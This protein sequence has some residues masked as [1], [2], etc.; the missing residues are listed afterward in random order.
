[1]KERG[2]FPGIAVVDYLYALVII[3][4]VFSMISSALMK[5]EKPANT[6][7]QIPNPTLFV[8]VVDWDGELDDDVDTYVTDPADHLVCFKRLKDGLMT[9]ERDD[10]GKISNTITSPEGKR[11]SALYN[12]ER[13]DI[14]G[15]IPGEYIVNVHMFRKA[16]LQPVKV[17]VILY[18]LKGANMKITEQTVVLS[19]HGGERTAFHFTLK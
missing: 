4:V 12:E 11:I 14:R 15:I 17:T 18:G 2:D 8:V 6:E 1:M 10:T 9:L 7:K 3:F 13:V 5:I 16:S 19:D